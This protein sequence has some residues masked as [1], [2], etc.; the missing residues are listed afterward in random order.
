MARL[1]A[2]LATTA[3]P[4]LGEAAR[5]AACPPAG[6]RALERAGRIV[7]LAPDLAYAT[8]TY[9]D[10]TTRALSMASQGPLTPAAFR[11]ATGTSRKYVMAILED[12]DRR[13]ILL[14]TPEGHVPGAK[15]PI[16]AG[17]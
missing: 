9:R 5:A 16:A 1:E 2:A 14:R 13:A 8:A 10:L 4:P 6:I 7:V 17:R 3:P 15:A 12:L 11:D